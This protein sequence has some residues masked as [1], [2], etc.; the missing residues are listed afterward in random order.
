[1]DLR[2]DPEAL[3]E[4]GPLAIFKDKETKMEVFLLLKL[5]LG[6]LA[7]GKVDDTKGMTLI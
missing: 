6:W 7:A 4:L 1:M 2:D 3:D 5:N